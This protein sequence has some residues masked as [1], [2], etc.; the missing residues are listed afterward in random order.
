M[1]ITSPSQENKK[2][3]WYFLEQS[4]TSNIS[5]TN[6]SNA[7]TWKHWGIR[8][9]NTV[10]TRTK[11]FGTRKQ[12]DSQDINSTRMRVRWRRNLCPTKAM[13][14][15]RSRW[16][17][18]DT[19]RVPHLLLFRPHPHQAN[20]PV[21]TPQTSPVRKARYVVNPVATIRVHVRTQKRGA[22]DIMVRFI[23]VHGR[24][25]FVLWVSFFFL[26]K[27]DVDIY[28]THTPMLSCCWA[29]RI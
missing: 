7:G 25:V 16:R 14:Y 22:V 5:N 4:H 10:D 28:H 19:A 29:Q 24:V 12:L 13:W 3:E 21:V 26:F 15:I 27:N 11:R 9:F 23:I 8:N 17:N 1:P 6:G 18:E 20:P 2:K